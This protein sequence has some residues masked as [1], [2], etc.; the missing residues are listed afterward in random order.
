MNRILKLLIVI[1]IFAL[2]TSACSSSPEEAVTA[3]DAEQPTAN[4]AKSEETS[5][6]ATTDEE[7]ETE[8]SPTEE[9]APPTATPVTA[10]FGDGEIQLVFW[11][12]LTGPD[13]VTMQTMVETFVAENPDISVRIEGMPWGIYY[14]KL[15]AA[16]VS[17]SPPDVFI[18]HEFNTAGY[19]ERGVLRSTDDLYVSGGGTLPDEDF[20]PELLERLIFDNGHYG[21]PLDNL[22]WGIW[23]NR[24]LFEAAGLDPDVMPTNADEFIE[25]AQQLTLDA[26][27]NNA[28]SADFDPE[29]IVQYG[30]IVWNPKNHYQGI[31]WQY[32]GDIFNG[33]DAMLDEEAAKEAAQLTYDLIYTYHVSPPPSGYNPQQAYAGGQLAIFP[34][35]TWGLNLAKN[36]EIDW[37][38]WPMLQ[39]GPE[40]ATR[41]SSH[42]LH[43]PAGLDGEQLEA[44]KRLITYLSDN[45]LAWAGSGQVPARFTVQEQLDPVEDR[46]VIVFAEAFKEQGR[47]E[48]P[49]V[50]KDEI[51]QSWEPEIDGMWNGVVG[52]EE[53]LATANERVQSVLD[54]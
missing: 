12:G 25:M 6:E 1:S 28:A 37:D 16:M 2:F 46:A 32:G 31:L 8:A 29:N 50:D 42:V 53:S 40:K 24:G 22:G 17:G 26:N 23:I 49:S 36:S 39:L 48:V 33:D 27:G 18:I 38:V 44:A 41:M 19:V 10:E 30:T 52:V 35:G 11:H 21:V 3:T 34:F 47:L 54:R 45:G 43:M 20:K 14:D 9:S 51:A 4:D 15:L 13:G 7:S 5:T